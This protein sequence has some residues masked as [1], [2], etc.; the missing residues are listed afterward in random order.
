LTG[1][2]RYVHLDRK[3]QDQVMD[4]KGVVKPSHHEVMIEVTIVRRSLLLK[5]TIKYSN[6]I[7]GIFFLSQNMGNITI[8]LF[9]PLTTLPL[10]PHFH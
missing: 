4:A 6:L 5:S 3:W 1:P 7:K 2:T 10:V 9:H 8:R